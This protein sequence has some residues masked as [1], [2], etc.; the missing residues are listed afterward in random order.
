VNGQI[1]HEFQMRLF[2]KHTKSTN[3]FLCTIKNLITTSK[4]NDNLNF[5]KVNYEH[6]DEILK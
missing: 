6:I 4:N 2:I 3:H 1:L 5:F